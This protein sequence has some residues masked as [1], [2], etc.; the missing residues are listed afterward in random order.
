MNERLEDIV[1]NNEKYKLDGVVAPKE[2]SGS[3][4][5]ALAATAAAGL[6]SWN[7]KPCDLI[8]RMK[9]E[10]KLKKL[11]LRQCSHDK[12]VVCVVGVSGVG[13][14][15]LVRNAYE[16]A[17][18]RGHFAIHIWTSFPPDTSDWIILPE[19]YRI[20]FDASSA[21][22]D[23]NHETGQ[24]EEMNLDKNG[25]G[26]MV[27][28]TAPYENWKNNMEI[29]LSNQSYLLVL[30]CRQI[31]ITKWQRILDNLPRGAAGSKIMLI[32]ELDE[33]YTGEDSETI[34]IDI[35]SH[36]KDHLV[37]MNLQGKLDITELNE[38]SSTSSHGRQI[39]L[40]NLSKLVLK[41][42]H[43]D[44][45]FINK[46]ASLKNLTSLLL[47]NDSFDGEKLVF[48]PN[49]FKK[50]KMLR[51]SHLDKVEKE[52]KIVVRSKMENLETFELIEFNGCVEAESP[53]IIDA[54]I[55]K[56]FY[57]KESLVVYACVF[58]NK[59]LVHFCA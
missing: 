2:A 17:E 45:D 34:G 33:G 32:T 22:N 38:G 56:T 30:D 20:F 26:N 58:A 13:K 9:E 3:N 14:T 27:G 11:L 55:N 23:L 47:L 16:D 5:A 41:Q 51:V 15:S 36:R 35:R 21:L 31:S 53:P 46:L 10:E 48:P 43:M 50:L 54:K 4:L 44:Q 52:K 40:S 18:I 6:P 49:G 59:S 1:K 39:S 42:T 12:D 24:Q 8:G 29:Q 25:S 28:W 7:A 19:I 37:F 57:S